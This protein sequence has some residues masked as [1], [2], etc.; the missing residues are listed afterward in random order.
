M[1]DIAKNISIFI[2]AFMA[3]VGL[4]TF[5][6]KPV[7]HRFVKWVTRATNVEKRD[8]VLE[9]LATSFSGFAEEVRSDFKEV[10]ADL[11]LSKQADKVLC[12]NRIMHMYEKYAESDSIPEGELDALEDHFAICE[13]LGTNGKI[14]R[15]YNALKEKR[16][17][18]QK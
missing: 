13:K 3:I 9:N 17:I 5:I 10:K 2:G 1:V 14:K 12:S 8:L 4:L 11:A 6:I 18:P 16:V 7:R 15:R